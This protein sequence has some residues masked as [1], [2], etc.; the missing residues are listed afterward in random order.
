MYTALKHS[1][2]LLAFI[3]IFGFIVRSI[4]AFKGSD[5]LQKKIVKIAPHII[6]TLLLLTAIGLMIISAQY[7]F[8]SAWVT[9]KFLGLVAYIILGVFTL[10][11]AKNN[12][13]RALFFTLAL[14]TITYIVV[15]ARTK[16]ALPFF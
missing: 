3:S 13:Q 5:L 8:V 9:A 4:W 16:T 14:L 11:K 2:M 7:P 15:V 12:Q 1:H 10:K 6:D